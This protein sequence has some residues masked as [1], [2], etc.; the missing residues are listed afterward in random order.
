MLADL[1]EVLRQKCEEEP[2]FK[3]CVLESEIF[4]RSRAET[5]SLIWY[6]RGHDKINREEFDEV[7]AKELVMY[8]LLH[9]PLENTVMAMKNTFSLVLFPGSRWARPSRIGSSICPMTWLFRSL[10]RPRGAYTT[11]KKLEVPFTVLYWTALF[12][13]LSAVIQRRKSSG[14]LVITTGPVGFDK[15]GL[16][17]T[18][19]VQPVRYFWRYHTRILFL[20]AFAALAVMAQWEP[21]KDAPAV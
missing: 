21:P 4:T 14:R 15:C 3:L 18:V 11:L 9:F 16:K 17:C 1:P 7:L 5:N 8:S 19:H 6:L 10:G 12:V 20:P 2:D 13:C